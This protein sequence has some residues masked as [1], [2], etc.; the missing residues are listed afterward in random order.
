MWLQ[1]DAF[2]NAAVFSVPTT[3]TEPRDAVHRPLLSDGELV[4]KLAHR[5]CALKLVLVNVSALNAVIH[6]SVEALEL[7]GEHVSGVAVGGGRLEHACAAQIDAA[8]VN[9]FLQ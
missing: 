5:H 4:E 3:N 2:E 7:S 9:V 8:H 1:C 6:A